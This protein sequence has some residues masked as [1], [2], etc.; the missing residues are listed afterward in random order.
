ML[1]KLQ[2]ELT[3]TPKIRT[4]ESS[5]VARTALIKSIA[6]HKSK[7]DGRVARKESSTSTKAT[8]LRTVEIHGAS[9]RKRR[10]PT[11]H[12][13]PQSTQPSISLQARGEWEPGMPS[14]D[15]AQRSEQ[16]Q[17]FPI[18]VG[19][20]AQSGW[21]GGNEMQFI[22]FPLVRRRTESTTPSRGNS[23]LETGLFKSTFQPVKRG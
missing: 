20:K 17:N 6:H 10:A 13:Q 16:R 7:G 19:R 18:A 2:S 14:I 3:N 15:V 8:S 9:Q 11:A 12:Y 5:L 1:A 22:F 21:K 23:A 4:G